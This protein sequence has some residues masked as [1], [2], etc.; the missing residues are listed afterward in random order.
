M[1][2]DEPRK[3]ARL[4]DR[5][6][7]TN[8]F[9][10]LTGPGD[11]SV[12]DAV[13]AMKERSYGCIVIV[14]EDNRVQGIVTERD[15]MYKL[16][17]HNSDP[18]TVKLSEIMTREIRMAKETDY[19][20]DWLRMMSNERFRRLPVVD[21]EG[22][23]QA[24]FTQGDFVSYTWPDLFDQARGLAKATFIGKFHYFLIGGGI[25]IYVLAMI[26]VLSAV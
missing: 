12:R 17:A 20:L 16:V 14:D 13:A 3:G 10:P 2:T 25:L 1:A 21:S 26:V 23:I 15:I 7:Y 5:P 24:L 8:K 22:R 11:M 9:H 6:E 4:M 19:V 18:D